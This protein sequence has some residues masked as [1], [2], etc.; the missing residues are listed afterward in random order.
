MIYEEDDLLNKLSEGYIFLNAHVTHT[1][2]NGKKKSK[3]ETKEDSK[4]RRAPNSVPKNRRIGFWSNPWGVLINKLK[5]IEGGVSINS[6]EGRLFRR[7][8]RVPWLVFLD[9]VKKSKEKLLFGANS[10]D[11]TDLC[12]SEICPVEIKLLGGFVF[13]VETGASTILQ[14]LL[15]WERLQ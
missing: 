7:R 8:F 11:K 14:K 10:L 4:R 6:R 13:W 9:L 1:I 15:E 12:G 3:H 2:N 5:A